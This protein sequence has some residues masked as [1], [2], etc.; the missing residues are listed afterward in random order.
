MA[1]DDAVLGVGADDLD[2][3]AVAVDVVEAGLGVVLDDEDRRVLPVLAVRDRVDD[4]ADR[5]VVVGDLGGRRSA[6]RRCGRWTARTC[7]GWPG[8]SSRSPASRSGTGRCPAPTVSNFGKPGTETLFSDGIGERRDQ[9]VGASAAPVAAMFLA[10]QYRFC[11]LARGGLGQELLEL[12][13][14]A[15]R[16]ARPPA[17]RSRGT[18]CSGGRGRRPRCRSCAGTHRPRTRCTPG[19]R[20]ASASCGPRRSSCR[21][22]RCCR[23]ARTAAPARAGSASRSRR[24]GSAPGRRCRAAS[25][26]KT[27]S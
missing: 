11:Q 18:R 13:E 9:R 20:P 10:S 17:R 16:L 22:R 7:S 3:G 15:H 2:R 26:P 1:V 14:V 21:C 25:S 4:L 24:T 23:T 5:E 27:W 12:A 19:C 6:G 8:R